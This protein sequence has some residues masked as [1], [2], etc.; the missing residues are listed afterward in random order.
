MNL[1]DGLVFLVDVVF[2]LYIYV[3]ILRVLLEFMRADYYN[4]LCQLVLKLTDRPVLFLQ[5]LLPRLSVID[6]PALILLIIVE[7]I[8][9]ALLC[10]I[11]AQVFPVFTFLKVIIADLVGQL[12]ML[13]CFMIILFAI[14][15]WVQNPRTAA[16]IF[17]LS[18][19]INPVLK[20]IRRIIP[21]ISG[22]DLSPLIALII[23]YF[24]YIVLVAPT[25]ARALI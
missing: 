9:L 3:I 18:T 2:S 15:S 20:P 7:L 10:L 14:L 24:I 21:L 1:S 23:L 12:I 25:M 11:T 8:K 5:K 6:L 13:Y 19:L 4:P 16:M 17:V 22:V